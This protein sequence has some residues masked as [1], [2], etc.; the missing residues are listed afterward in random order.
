MLV[1]EEP[2]KK[3]KSTWNVTK[4]RETCKYCGKTTTLVNY[5]RYHGRKGYKCRERI[6]KEK[7]RRTWHYAS[8]KYLEY[9]RTKPEMRDSI[10]LA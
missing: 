6:K 10:L 8:P 3:V 2:E 1:C 4:R 7:A 5:R 9:I